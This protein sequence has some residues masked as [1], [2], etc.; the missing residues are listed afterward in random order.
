MN[1]QKRSGKDI[2]FTVIFAGRFLAL[3]LNVL[4]FFSLGRLQGQSLLLFQR[5]GFLPS[6]TMSVLLNPL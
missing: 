6:H 2:D 5:D 4:N 3:G 1:Q